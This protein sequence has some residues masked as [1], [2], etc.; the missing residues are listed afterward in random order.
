MF[1]EQNMLKTQS[2]LFNCSPPPQFGLIVGDDYFGGP[3]WFLFITKTKQV[4][5]YSK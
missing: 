5:W 1:G 3:L 2:K 4:T